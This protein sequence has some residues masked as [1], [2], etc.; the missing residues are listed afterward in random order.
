MPDR[1]TL[2]LYWSPDSSELFVSTNRHGTWIYHPKDTD[3]IPKRFDE[4][5]E[6]MTFSTDSR[7]LFFTTSNGDLHIWGTQPYRPIHRMPLLGEGKWLKLFASPDPNHVLVWRGAHNSDNILNT[8]KIWL[9]HVLTGELLFSPDHDEVIHPILNADGRKLFYMDFTSTGYIW[10]I[11]TGSQIAKWE[12]NWLHNTPEQSVLKFRWHEE[13]IAGYYSSIDW[14]KRRTVYHTALWNPTTDEE[15]F[16]NFEDLTTLFESFKWEPDKIRM[17][18]ETDYDD[19]MNVF[20]RIRVQIWNPDQK[21][22]YMEF[23]MEEYQPLSLSPDEALLAC[24]QP[25]GIAL[26]DY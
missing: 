3:N 10:D 11:A 15:Q 19:E 23:D 1:D 12:S 24:S 7:H 26:Y 4:D 18:T 16:F 17:D 5:V 21:R 6:A 9:Y 20:E 25:D 8:T 22:T 13:Q 2:N 14:D